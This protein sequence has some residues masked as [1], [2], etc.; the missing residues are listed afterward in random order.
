MNP[1]LM[2]VISPM[3]EPLIL[4]DASEF[5]AAT[6]ETI[7]IWK[8]ENRL[9]NIVTPVLFQKLGTFYV[10][11]FNNDIRLAQLLI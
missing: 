3:D 5:V 10:C 9:I 6:K 4:E 11:M 1:Y 7:E 8:T 2:P